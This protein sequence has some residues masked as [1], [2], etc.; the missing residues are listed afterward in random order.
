MI[1]CP[2]RDLITRRTDYRL[3]DDVEL[4]VSAASCVPRIKRKTGIG[5]GEGEYRVGEFGRDSHWDMI[6]QSTK[7]HRNCP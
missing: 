7:A 5:I 4:A 1:V 6:L 2:W 3:E